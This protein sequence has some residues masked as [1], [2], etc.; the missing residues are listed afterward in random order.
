MADT[1]L[2]REVTPEEL[3]RRAVV[4]M[5]ALV[6]LDA[7]RGRLRSGRLVREGTRAYVENED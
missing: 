2:P 7:H 4:A 1:K 3:E 5:K 6:E